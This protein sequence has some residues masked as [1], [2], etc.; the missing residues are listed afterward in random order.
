[1]L[2]KYYYLMS[3]SLVFVIPSVIAGYF[4]PSTI[5]ISQ[6]II[7]I[8]LVTIVG[9]LWDLWATQ[10]GKKDSVWL[11][12]FNTKNTLG[13]KF[14]GLPI[15][16]YLFY[17]ASSVYVIFLWTSIQLAMQTGN[18]SLY[19]L[20]PCL[21]IWTALSISIPYKLSPNNDKVLG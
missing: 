11:W 18:A 10:H 19:F 12:S 9:S 7:F 16:E 5:A 15:E 1:M 3:L 13:I 21:A 4:V 8:F 6:L 17:T 2:E 20:M 14:L